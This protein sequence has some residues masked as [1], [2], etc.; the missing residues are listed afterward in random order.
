VLSLF[1]SSTFALTSHQIETIKLGWHAPY[2]DRTIEYVEQIAKHQELVKNPAF[3]YD[4]NHNYTYKLPQ[5]VLDE[6]AHPWMWLTLISL[7]LADIH[8][9]HEG[10]KYDCIREANP[11]LPSRPT[12]GEMASFKLAIM[13]PAYDSVGFEN[14][15]NRELIFPIIF[16]AG[17]VANNYNVVGKARHRCSLR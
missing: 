9:T 7:Q 13:I 4:P 2:S 10:V 17:V 12:I 5:S 1:S 14:I 11:L 6:P 3:R 16:T 8:S 15:T